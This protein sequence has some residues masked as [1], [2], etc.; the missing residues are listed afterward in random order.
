M[1]TPKIKT[2]N[3]PSY[4]NKPMWHDK[5]VKKMEDPKTS[6]KTHPETLELYKSLFS[7]LKPISEVANKKIQA[8]AK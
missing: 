3:Y 1:N 8:A 6:G 7:G 5:V 2:A 4:F